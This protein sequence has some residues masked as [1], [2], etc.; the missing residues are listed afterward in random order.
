[1]SLPY[2]RRYPTDLWGDSKVQQMSGAAQLAHAGLLD[3]AHQGPVR[4]PGALLRRWEQPEEL[5]EEIR[6]LWYETPEGWRQKR[7]DQEIAWGQSRREK[8]QAAVQAREAMR[9]SPRSSDDD[10][11]MNAR[12]SNDHLTSTSTRTRTSTRTIQPEE[13]TTP[14]GDGSPS[15]TKA[16]KSRK[17][18]EGQTR[19]AV[20]SFLGLQALPGFVEA[21]LAWREAL[22]AKKRWAS[23]AALRS[24]LT[25]LE[26]HREDALDLVRI[27]T[28]ECWTDPVHAEKRLLERRGKANGRAKSDGYYR[29]PDNR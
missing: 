18:T 6:E 22:G 20:E 4:N 26:K 21:V 5:W 1:M 12:S 16:K 29:H 2:Y 17:P 15:E 27:A 23:V 3:F 13:E 24:R 10:R 7:M 8:A 19:A 11:T 14:S 9:N 28:E 25:W